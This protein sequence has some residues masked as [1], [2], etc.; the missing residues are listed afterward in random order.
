[1]FG[2]CHRLG[3]GAAAYA[4]SHPEFLRSLLSKKKISP[5]DSF[6]L[7][8]KVETTTGEPL[9]TSSISL[10]DAVKIDI[11]KLTENLLHWTW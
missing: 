7:I 9:T 10:M 5:E 1:L 3:T 11:G 2:G 8:L 4:V 6:E